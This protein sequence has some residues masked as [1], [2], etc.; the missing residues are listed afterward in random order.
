M[1]YNALG[2]PTEI[3]LGNGL[4][5]T[6]TYWGLDYGTKSY[7]RLYEIKTLPLSGGT[8][9]QDV[10]HTWD[11]DGDLSS[12]YDSLT[13]DTENFGY[14]SLDRL[15]GVSGNYTQGYS[16]NAIGNI[17]SM[18]GVNYSYGT[19][20]HAVTS[21]G[22]T[23]YAYDANGN[24]I[25]RGS[26]SFNWDAENRPTS[27]TTNGTT[28]YYVYDGDGNRVMQTSNNQTTLYIN[29]CNEINLSTNTTISYYYLG[30]ALIAMSTNTTLQYIHKDELGGTSVMS[31]ASGTLLGTMKYTPF[32][33]TRLITGSI[34]TNKLFT[35]Q[36]LDDTGLY[37]YNARYYD[38]TI[39][40]FISSD[41]IIQN[42]ANPQSFNR[43][44]YCCNN[45]LKYVDPSGNQYEYDYYTLAMSKAAVG[46]TK[47]AME[48]AQDAVEQSEQLKNY[49]KT[50]MKSGI[51]IVP[52][53]GTE[54]PGGSQV[55]KEI[56]QYEVDL[57]GKSYTLTACTS[58]S[59]NNNPEYTQYNLSGTGDLTLTV[60]SSYGISSSDVMK[61]ALDL[62]ALGVSGNLYILD[63]GFWFMN[64]TFTQTPNQNG[65]ITASSNGVAY[66]TW[67]L[68]TTPNYDVFQYIETDW[69]SLDPET[70]NDVYGIYEGLLHEHY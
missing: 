36:V 9:I 45:P 18:N 65:T 23:S 54:L 19:Q 8:A 25:T 49:G 64:G 16:Y 1:T 28:V 27:I 44:S 12:R 22:S 59:D 34:T 15:T 62:S 33:Q 47:G 48:D 70:F 58:Y 2:D 17:M 42:P 61:I 60:K 68:I 32:G 63:S 24:M 3:D 52:L 11:A 5:T 53:P 4:K 20:P 35:G 31:S 38:P 41:K 13:S 21:V 14:D 66:A 51:V 7:G 30:S 57:N 43:Y 29:Q 6:Y 50:P 40:R 55:F 69:E 67:E 39:G 56:T 26:Q 10:T 37:Y 46:D